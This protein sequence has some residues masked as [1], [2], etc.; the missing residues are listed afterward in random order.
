VITSLAGRALADPQRVYE[1]ADD[2]RRKLLGQIWPDLHAALD[3]A[4]RQAT[5]DRPVICAM[6]H[7]PPYPRATGR[8]TLNGTPAC[9][10]HL[11]NSTRPGGYPLKRVDPREWS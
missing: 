11:K 1:Q 8:M 6:G 9:P 5:A 7:R 3:K 10:G 2:H 4:H